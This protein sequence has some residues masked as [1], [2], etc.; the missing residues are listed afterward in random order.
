M[1]PDQL[2]SL[3]QS[4]KDNEVFQRALTSIRDDALNALATMP[5]SDE[6]GFYSARARVA[7]VD[8]LRDNIEQV[9][10]SGRLKSAPGLA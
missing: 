4:L 6:D 5:R 9:I 8:A 2:A 1:T 3:A 10:R 7:V